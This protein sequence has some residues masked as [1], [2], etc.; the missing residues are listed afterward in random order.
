MNTKVLS[1]FLFIYIF[2]SNGFEAF[3]QQGLT[4]W[5]SSKPIS[6]PEVASDIPFFDYAD[7]VLFF[8]CKIPDTIEKVF[9]LKI[10]ITPNNK[11]KIKKLIQFDEFNFDEAQS[12]CE[13]QI[14]LHEQN[15]YA[16]NFDVN[17]SFF[18]K[19]KNCVGKALCMIQLLRPNSLPHMESETIEEIDMSAD[20]N[21][22]HIEKTF[23]QSYSI[24]R[25]KTNIAALMPIAES[26]EGRFIKDIENIDDEQAIRRF[27]YNF[28]SARN[29]KQ[30]EKEWKYYA[31]ALNEVAKLYGNA[32]QKGYESDRGRIYLKYGKP[33]K[34]D[35]INNEAGA[36][37]YEI[38]VYYMIDQNPNQKI[39]FYQ[40]GVFSNYLL[41]L[42]S[43]LKDELV[44]PQWET[45]LLQDPTDNEKK[46]KY[47]VYEYF[48]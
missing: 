31:Q 25:L 6:I 21:L 17:F 39:L 4:V 14:I 44:N 37:P 35:R 40:P 2:I 43:T 48:N 20:Q 38:W 36:L 5:V 30:P 12:L 13:H 11:S 46:L 33:D 22:V 28:W 10:I 7:S 15:F 41:I 32:S 29:L 27:F 42:H 24:E 16:G 23:V 18:D 47:K 1:C 19:N 26:N 45:Y 9:S 3:S 8:S 34:I